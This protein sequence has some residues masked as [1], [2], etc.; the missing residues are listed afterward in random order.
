MSGIDIL[1]GARYT[2]PIQVFSYFPW[3]HIFQLKKNYLF[4]RQCMRK[5]G[6]IYHGDGKGKFS[7]RSRD[8]LTHYNGPRTQFYVLANVPVLDF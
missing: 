8:Y 3:G 6:A 4:T 1:V 2:R 7:A 5:L